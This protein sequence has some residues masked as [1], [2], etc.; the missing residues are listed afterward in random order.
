VT[1]SYFGIIETVVQFVIYEYLRD[2]IIDPER[3]FVGFS[4]D[5]QQTAFIQFM[6]AGGI[7]KACAVIIAYPHGKKSS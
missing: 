6:F 7:A 1:G 2:V 5:K 4:A 3:K